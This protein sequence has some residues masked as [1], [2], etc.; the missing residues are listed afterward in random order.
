MTAAKNEIN[1]LL[2]NSINRR[3]LIVGATGLAVPLLGVF[4]GETLWA[5]RAVAQ[6]EPTQGGA[7]TWADYEPNTMNPYIASEA[8]ARSAI[9]VVNRGLTVSPDGRV[10]P[11][12]VTE[13]PVRKRTVASRMTARQ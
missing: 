8:I 11:V 9:A 3:S 2:R 12:M 5:R 7:I 4:P 13:I 10:M 1:A 6:A